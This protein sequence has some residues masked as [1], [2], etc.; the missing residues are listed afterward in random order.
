[1]A[2][3]IQTS[4]A[5]AATIGA[6]HSLFTVTSPGVWQ[7]LV[8]ASGLKNATTP[9]T[10]TADYGIVE[11]WG[12][13]IATGTSRLIASRIIGPG[14]Q[15]EQIYN[16][17]PM[18][19]PHFQVKLRQPRNQSRTWPWA[20]YKLGTPTLATSGAQAATVGATHTLFT[21]TTKGVYQFV[22]SVTGLQ[23][24]GAGATGE[25]VAFDF[26]EKIYASATRRLATR[27]T[28]GPG[29]QTEDIFI[30]VPFSV[31]AELRCNLRQEKGTSRTFG[32]SL[33][34]VS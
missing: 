7:L 32:W 23:H 10:A 31:G 1:L 2:V 19:L 28:F 17:W 22:C 14:L 5:Q 26:Y 11:F 34:R 30:S 33:W 4:G 6:T 3:T 9:A 18:M 13:V 16:A 21:V 24:G 15:T 25:R 12:R 8:S 20:L 29:V 27:R